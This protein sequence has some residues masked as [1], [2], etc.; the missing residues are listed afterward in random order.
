MGNYLP[1]VNVN[2]QVISN[3]AGYEFSC[4]HLFDLTIKCWGEN[5]LGQLG[6]GDAQDRGDGANEMGEYLPTIDVG[7]SVLI[8]DIATGTYHTFILTDQQKLKAWGQGQYGSL[9]YGDGSNR[10]NNPSQMGSYLPFVEVGSG[11]KIKAIRGSPGISCVILDNLSVKCFGYG[12]DGRLGQESN[13][14]IGDDGS[15]MGDYLQPIKLPN[16]VAS[17]KLVGGWAQVGIISTNGMIFLWG[18]NS[19]GQLG[20]G[21]TENIGDF[22]NEM[23]NYLVETK[24]GSGRTVIGMAGGEFHTCELLDNYEV[25]CHGDASEGQLGSGDVID[26]GKMANEM[27]DYLSYLNFGQQG[28]NAIELIGGHQHTCAIFNDLSLKCW[29]NNQVG[30][31]GYGDTSDRGNSANQ[32]SDYLP[33]I[34]LG[35]GV[36]IQ[37]CHDFS[38]TA[39]PSV[40]FSPTFSPTTP[41]PTLHPSVYVPVSCN[42]DI[43]GETH[44][45]VLTSSSQMKCFGRNNLGQLG[46]GDV[47]HRGEMASQMGDYLP[48]VNINGNVIQTHSGVHRNCV[49][50]DTL[51]ITCFG[52]NNYGQLGYGDAVERGSAPNQM[53]L[54]LSTVALGT[55]FLA[56]GISTG[57]QHTCVLSDLSLLKCFGKNEKAPLGLGDANHR[58]D[59]ANEMNDYLPYVNV[60]STGSI[61]AVKVGGWCSCVLF[62]DGE[63]KCWGENDWG[64]LG[65]GSVI[66]LGDAPNELGDYLPPINF[67]TGVMI[68][69]M[70]S[71]TT[72]T[73]IISMNGYLYTWGLNSFGELGIGSTIT[74]GD[75]NNEL[76]DY[77]RTTNLGSGNTVL[78]FTAGVSNSCAILDNYRVKCWGLNTSG[79]VK[80]SCI[81]LEILVDISS[82]LVG[83][84]GYNQQRKCRVSDGELL[85]IRKSRTW[86]YSNFHSCRKLSFLRLLK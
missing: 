12:F 74:I 20:I 86:S 35:T 16:G 52:K 15:E 48:F 11:L 69:S 22:A 67:P 85:T 68:Q 43:S 47:T 45:C 17:S 26:R 39:N 65:Q 82:C 63:M 6:Y 10:G 34:N 55:S 62:D 80:F 14:D 36:E 32:M 23:G 64:Q 21:S 4:T 25:K 5:S 8:S 75:G 53:G 31:L 51:E 13:N 7:P 79:Q 83:I 2:S 61:K 38:P 76:G 60:G 71:G 73:A 58:G 27:G 56:S 24:L 41:S 81:Y 33:F 50:L 72:L 70:G 57:S 3:Q 77:L 1:F 59:D 42:S 28:L 66:Q 40:T 30:E 9:G 37:S 18:E 29:G 44:N 84:W 49:Q 78:G 19:D 46:Y 54:Y